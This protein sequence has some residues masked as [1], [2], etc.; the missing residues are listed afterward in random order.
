MPSAIA[1]NSKTRGY[2]IASLTFARSI[3]GSKCREGANDAEGILSKFD[4]GATGKKAF[5]VCLAHYFV[6]VF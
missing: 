5:A 6:C 4:V 3:L 1:N 2:M